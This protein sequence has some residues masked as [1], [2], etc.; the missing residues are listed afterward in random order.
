MAQKKKKTAKQRVAPK[1]TVK[2]P[3]KPDQPLV[4]R[5]REVA[6][7]LAGRKPKLPAR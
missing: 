7:R 3:S 5:H 2:L 4:V 6:K 1:R